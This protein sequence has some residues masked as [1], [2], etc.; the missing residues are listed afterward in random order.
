MPH[1]IIRQA[2]HPIA[3]SLRHGRE[4]LGIGLVFKGIA[5]E[6]DAGAM[7]VGF[8]EDI[9]AADAVERDFAVE[10][11]EA[12]LAVVVGHPVEVGA[13]GAVFFVACDLGVD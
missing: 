12:F 4:T 1:H 5:R 13:V 8:D 11:F 7:D 6:I 2:P 9:D 10:V 3:G